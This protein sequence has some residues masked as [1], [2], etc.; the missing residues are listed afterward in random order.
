MNTILSVISD[1]VI[2]LQTSSVDLR[3]TPRFQ[4]AI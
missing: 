2:S 1:E 4:S 3:D